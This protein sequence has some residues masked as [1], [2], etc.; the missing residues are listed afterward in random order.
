M[1]VFRLCFPNK[2]RVVNFDFIS[3]VHFSVKHMRSIVI[4][5]N[6]IGL[7][8]K[9]KHYASIRKEIQ[10]TLTNRKFVFIRVEVS[11]VK[12]KIN[13]YVAQV[14]NTNTN[15]NVVR[16]VCFSGRFSLMH[17]F[18]ILHVTIANRIMYRMIVEHRTKFIPSIET[19]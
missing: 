10:T 2:I 17:I 12:T 5:I 7:K 9:S 16:S 8:S 14:Q 3:V 6:E 13:K 18:N 15:S 11:A 1:V 4:P 19:P